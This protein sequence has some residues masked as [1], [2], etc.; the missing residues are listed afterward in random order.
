MW[1]HA[2]S[3]RAW[4]SWPEQPV[5]AALQPMASTMKAAARCDHAGL[6]AEPVG[7][8]VEEKAGH[9][10]RPVECVAEQLLARQHPGK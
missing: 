8:I 10:E 9:S 3:A 7:G 2:W 6:F 4:E 5:N 1:L